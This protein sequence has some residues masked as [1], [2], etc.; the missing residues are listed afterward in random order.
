[1]LKMIKIMN[2]LL[3]IL[4]HSKNVYDQEENRK[5]S[6]IRLRALGVGVGV[7]V[8]GSSKN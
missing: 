4:Y 2:S 7:G 8:A 5:T 6:E 1:M 3:C